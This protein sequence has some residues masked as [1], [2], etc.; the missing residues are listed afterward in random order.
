M[1]ISRFIEHSGAMTYGLYSKILATGDVK[2]AIDNLRYTLF[3]AIPILA[4]IIVL[5]KPILFVLNPLYG[6][7]SI[8]VILFSFHMFLFVIFTF[9]INV[10]RGKDEIDVDKKNNFKKY[11]NSDLFKT[12]TISLI[13]SASY[14]ITLVVLLYS[15]IF[16]NTD[17]EL[18]T[19]W[20]MILLVFTTIFTTYTLILLKRK[21]SV[22]LPYL[23]MIK[24]ALATIPLIIITNY[25]L[26][27]FFIYS[28]DL[29][30]L[31]IHTLLLVIVGLVIYISIT[32]IIDKPCRNLMIKCIM[33]I[34][35]IRK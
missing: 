20:T 28:N 12:S 34:N 27:Q 4:L 14:I 1:T 26:E 2:Y 29:M 21:Y 16:G 32:I 11:I 13:Y 7:I 10:L 3:I 6:H 8:P 33:E 17:L 24:Y 35:K 19:G 25:I 18:I 31:V 9:S 15:G 30:H 22:S 5:S 23:S